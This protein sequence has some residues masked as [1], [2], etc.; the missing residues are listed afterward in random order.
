MIFH[1]A[2]IRPPDPGSLM[3]GYSRFYPSF[4]RRSTKERG[5]LPCLCLPL[6][7]KGWATDL[8]LERSGTRS[9]ERPRRHD[10]TNHG[11]IERLKKCA[12]SLGNN[13]SNGKDNQCQGHS[14]P[15]K[16]NNLRLP[17]YE[18]GQHQH[19]GNDLNSKHT[20]SIYACE[21]LRQATQSRIKKG[22]DG[23]YRAG[24]TDFRSLKKA[25]S[26]TLT[27]TRNSRKATGRSTI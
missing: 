1:R 17:H 19:A 7:P 23:S 20:Y 14:H 6:S 13:D 8:F 26:D 18:E 16:G 15:K 10:R 5:T 24:A 22:K 12:R 25:C 2:G 9:V 27:D 21:C 3:K 4:R 11:H